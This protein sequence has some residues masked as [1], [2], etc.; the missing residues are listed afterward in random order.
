MSCLGRSLPAAHSRPPWLFTME[1]ADRESHSHAA[2]FGR[3]E[4][5]KDLFHGVF[6]S[7]P[8]PESLTATTDLFGITV[9][10][11]DHEFSCPF[12]DTAHRLDCIHDQVQHDLL[13][14]NPIA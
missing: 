11:R 14:L 5:V 6:W 9:F 7:R 10:G 13:Q 4:R 8:V 12:L 1:A 3:I 2:G